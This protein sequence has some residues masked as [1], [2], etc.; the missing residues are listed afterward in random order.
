MIEN[1]SNRLLDSIT[2]KDMI[3][4]KIGYL[5]C[6]NQNIK[7]SQK[8]YLIYQN[9]NL[10][11]MIGGKCQKRKLTVLFLKILTKL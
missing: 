2:E 5:L 10:V 9:L 1:I 4:I 3:D 6:K 7:L 11:I 8:T